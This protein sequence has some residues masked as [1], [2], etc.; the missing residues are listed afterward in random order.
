VRAVGLLEKRYGKVAP[1][2]FGP[3]NGL[4]LVY[5]WGKLDA[6]GADAYYLRSIASLERSPDAAEAGLPTLLNN[7]GYFLLRGGEPARAEPVFRRALALVKP[8]IP[9]ETGLRIF[10]LIGLGHVAAAGKAFDEAESDYRQALD[11]AGRPDSP[12]APDTP[13]TSLAAL[14]L[15]RNQVDRAGALADEILRADTRSIEKGTM[16]NLEA[17]GLRLQVFLLK[18]EIARAVEFESRLEEIFEQILARNLGASASGDQA[19]YAA[20]FV[21]LANGPLSIHIDTAPN[22]PGA[23]RLALTTILRRKGR[24][25]DAMAASVSALRRR[26]GEEDVRLLGDLATAR[27]RLAAL[28]FESGDAD[29]ARN[30]EIGQ[31][32][33]RI[34]E[35]EVRVSLR[36]SEAQAVSRPIT[37]E[38][39]RAKIPRDAALVEYFVYRPMKVPQAGRTVSAFDLV[40]APR[41]VAYVLRAEGEP[42][43][44]DLGG[45]EAID[46]L[47]AEFRASLR[48]PQRGDVRRHA[49]ALDR[50][51]MQPVRGLLRDARRLLVSPDGSLTLVPFAA[52]VD[53][54]NR[55]LVSRYEI[56][57]LTSGRDLLSADARVASRQGPLVVANPD[58]G[59]TGPTS[60]SRDI[61]HATAPGS[62]AKIFFRDLP[63]TKDE[64]R[65]LG[66]LLPG[67]TVLVRAEAS[68]RAVKRVTGPRILH[69]ATHGFFL[70]SV[71]PVGFGARGLELGSAGAPSPPVE[72][73]PLLRAGVALAGANLGAADGEDGILTALEV[74]GLD[75]WGT[76]LVVL[77]ACDTGVGVVR[78][79]EGVYGLRRALV[80]AGSETQVMSLW[81]V[82]DAGTR[83][84]MAGYYRRLLAGEGRGE[85]LRRVQLAMLENPTR[86]HPFYWAS[87]IVSGE[88]AR[89][90]AS[91]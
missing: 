83:D 58:Y 89:L 46:R 60:G 2:L 33:E 12:I 76:R 68:E 65:I 70:D 47:V 71:R 77:S 51:V 21:L 41:Y 43:G 84:L 61:A 28:T 57:Y 6:K 14:A 45:A 5:D 74:A 63:G 24:A 88:W 39:V 19:V 48:T 64:A 54:R 15:A 80:L 91:P 9:G 49:R 3:L 8:G 72:T 35:L 73:N 13:K 16:P 11:L 53:E 23:R 30:V 67:A 38:A 82:S 37:L 4:A 55:Y 32:R 1:E 69:V 85:A 10:L 44:V 81:P 56:D 20:K 7:Y 34:A 87:V 75:L 50:A 90:D 22:D 18:G 52:L 26:L 17:A 40:G 78:T 86:R 31:L 59:Q 42:A 29:E 79:G 36:G 25:L 27:S 62:T 66:A